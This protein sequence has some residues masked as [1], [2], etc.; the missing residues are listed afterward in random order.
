MPRSNTGRQAAVARISVRSLPL[1]ERLAQRDSLT[2]WFSITSVSQTF[3]GGD[4]DDH[5]CYPPRTA[6]L[7]NPASAL[8]PRDGAAILLKIPSSCTVLRG[9]APTMKRPP[10]R[11]SDSHLPSPANENTPDSVMF[12]VQVL[13]PRDLPLTQTEI[14]VFALLLDDWD[15]LAANDNEEQCK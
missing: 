8:R 12:R 6:V 14:E 3:D 5:R 2:R 10:K 7:A 11:G 4:R 1:D 15:G 9:G 13:I